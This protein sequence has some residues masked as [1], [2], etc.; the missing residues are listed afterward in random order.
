MAKKSKAPALPDT[1]VNA[2][3]H[4]VMALRDCYD[5]VDHKR[6]AKMSASEKSNL[7]ADQKQQVKSLM[8]SDSL[9]MSKVLETKL[10]FIAGEEQGIYKANNYGYF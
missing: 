5:K 7:C 2:F 1:Q 10:E 4:S 9:V 3:F 8:N 6:A